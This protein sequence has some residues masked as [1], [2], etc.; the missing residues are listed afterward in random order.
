[1]TGTVRTWS[2]SYGFIN[3]TDGKSIFV[4]QTAIHGD[5]YRE[6]HEGER[7]EFDVEESPRG[8]RAINVRRTE[9][10]AQRAG[11]EA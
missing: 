1:M 3:T 11:E 8:Q 9:A 10:S 2:G 6:L 5:G 4:H 7:I